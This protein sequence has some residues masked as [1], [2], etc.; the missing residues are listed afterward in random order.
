MGLREMTSSVKW[1]LYWIMAIAALVAGL[2]LGGAFHH[3]QPAAPLTADVLPEPR[4]LPVLHLKD[5]DG[6]TF[7]NA[8]LRG[9]W[10]FLFLG[11]THCPDI[12]PT[13]LS[14]LN[15]MVQL[16]KQQGGSVPRVFFVS[17]DPKRDTPPVLKQ[18][19]HFFNPDF[20]GVTGNLAQL[21]ALA[22]SLSTTFFYDPP[23]RTGNYIVGHP[24][25]V[26]LINPQGRLAAIDMP[27]LL[28]KTMAQDY[29]TIIARTGDA[30]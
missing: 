6:R 27:P 12:C 3:T 9:Q 18:Y 14:D 24:A 23:S 1:L 8:N 11:Y 22:T 13:T 21:H 16:L 19:L 17:V 30:G 28:P 2:W 4:P 29:R 10:S 20:V 26:F 5:E 7:T 25:M 15:S